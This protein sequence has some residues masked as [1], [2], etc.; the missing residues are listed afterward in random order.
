MKKT[1]LLSSVLTLL[2]T[3]C[4]QKGPEIKDEPKVNLTKEEVVPQ[5][6]IKEIKTPTSQPKIDVKPI[7]SEEIG[8]ITNALSEQKETTS[9][10]SIDNGIQP[11]Y[12]DYDKFELREDMYSL[13]LKNIKLLNNKPVKLEGNCDEFGSDEYNVALGLKRANTVKRFLLDNGYDENKISMVSYGEG[14]PICSE[15]TEECY[16]K[17]RRVELKQ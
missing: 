12:F 7:E 10:A 3:G 8:A 6:Q 11:I 17:N 2:L 15:S 13:M 14:N 4:Y 5:F 9:I 1:I 16:S